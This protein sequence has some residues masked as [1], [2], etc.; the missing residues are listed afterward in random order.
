MDATHPRRHLAA[1][2]RSITVRTMRAPPPIRATDLTRLAFSESALY[3]IPPSP[4]VG[5][6]YVKH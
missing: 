4:L 1:M 6:S 5:V 3:Y 2:A